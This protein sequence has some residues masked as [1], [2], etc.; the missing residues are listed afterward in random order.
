MNLADLDVSLDG[1]AVLDDVHAFTGRYVAFPSAAC[2]VA[3]T[4]WAAHAHCAEAAD[5]TPRLALLSPE[6]GSG[7]TRT[8]EVLELLTPR[9]MFV[10]SAS[11]AAIFRTIENERPSLLFDECDA[12]FT[13][14]G[15]DDTNEDLRALLNAGHR[16][17]ATI[18]R[19]VGPLHNVQRFPVYCPVALAGLGDL[20]ATLMS[21]SVVIRMRRRGPG[22][23]VEPFRHREAAP[24][25]R[26][27]AGR[28]AGWAAS[29]GDE[30][31]K[32]WPDMPP[33][34]T[35]RPA[36]V[37]EPLLAIADAAGGDW[38]KRA[39]EA[40]AELAAAAETAEAS[41]GVRL[42]TDLYEVFGAAE[43]LPT[44]AILDRL[45]AIEDAPWAALGRQAKP[46]D[47]RGL[48]TRLRSYDVKSA[49]LPRD[50]ETR[51]KG[52]LAA[53]LRDPWTRY[54]PASRIAVPAVP[55]RQPQADDLFSGTAAQPGTDTAVPPR[56][57]VPA[58]NV[59]TSTVTDGTDGTPLREPET[60]PRPGE[61]HLGYAQR[62][63]R[64]RRGGAQ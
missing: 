44:A 30:L 60:G 19:C 37:W 59:L 62:L 38:P 4:L 46:L 42:L 12:I 63:A 8:L 17:G 10:L 35:D 54:V 45:H 34:I 41:L 22:E 29:A 6:P 58:G 1:A 36:D 20:P 33:G 47:A 43:Q 25:G 14:H 24:A 51:Q 9:P 23:H 40:C 13:R 64:E 3:V 31:A 28:I 55:P 49:T 15:K 11:P 57:A 7:K 16:K 61:S 27:L 56:D 26:A 5:S 48:A 21:R 18:P 53:G 50:G 32:A 52:Y 2:A 39:R